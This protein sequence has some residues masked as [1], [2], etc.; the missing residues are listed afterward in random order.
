MTFEDILARCL[1]D[2]EQGETIEHCVARYP[3]HAAE[4]ISL[5]NLAV[6]VR[7]TPQPRLSASGFARGQ[8]VVAAQARLH[9][10]HY[11]PFNPARGLA[12]QKLPLQ[13]APT[14][15][16]VAQKF[17]AR[18]PK[19]AKPFLLIYKAQ[20][21]LIAILIVLSLFAL[22]R[23]I[24]SSLPGA[25]L[26]PVKILGENMQGVLLT[27]AGQQAAWHAHQT[28]IR[29]QELTRLGQQDPVASA[30]LAQT[31]DQ[32]VAATLHASNQWPTEQ[33]NQFLLAW[34]TRLRTLDKNNQW[35]NVVARTLDQT[36]ATIQTA[37]QVTIAVPTTSPEPIQ[38]VAPTSTP[39][40]VQI[41]LPTTAAHQT[42]MEPQLPAPTPPAPEV[43]LPA[44]TPASLH[45]PSISPDLAP[46]TPTVL[47]TATIAPFMVQLPQ[48]T[49][50]GDDHQS[51]Q[52]N[53]AAVAEP[54]QPTA[55]V[56]AAAESQT[57]DTQDNKEQAKIR[58]STSVTTSLDSGPEKASTPDNPG[59]S[60][61]ATATATPA[62]GIADTPTPATGSGP[63]IVTVTPFGTEAA[64][65]APAEQTAIV[66]TGT[67][68]ADKTSTPVAMP[69]STESNIPTSAP[70]KTSTSEPEN[71]QESTATSEPVAT[72]KPTATAKPTK[73]DPTNTPD[74]NEA[75]DE[76]Q[77]T[78]TLE[79][80]PTPKKRR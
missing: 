54:E 58:P 52:P 11:A 48:E 77:P 72:P 25:T 78:S 49:P 16:V 30:Q 17:V 24:S 21:A 55:P 39:A 4:L 65:L 73:S 69:S 37:T 12:A 23:N 6:A 61:T 27:A 67:P 2:L 66:S 40:A 74:K 41:S 14:Q 43:T 7:G 13:T 32:Q 76:P 33:R 18:P 75:T 79:S 42:T 20:S 59:E 71:T 8:A 35:P 70:A 46:A 19:L 50:V 56:V 26:Y 64:T 53:K 57:A 9:Q 5:L 38:V 45:P 10:A 1:D 60:D 51:E 28:E 22:A 44:A 36:L 34:L 31:I 47:A 3:Q 80:T 62:F 68:A 63:A 15:P 29:L